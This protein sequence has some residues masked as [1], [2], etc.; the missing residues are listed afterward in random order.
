MAILFQLSFIA[1]VLSCIDGPRCAHHA[2]IVVTIVLENSSDVTLRSGNHWLHWK[3]TWEYWTHATHKLFNKI[4]TLLRLPDTL[5]TQKSCTYISHVHQQLHLQTWM[6]TEQCLDSPLF[7]KLFFLTTAPWFYQIAATSTAPP[8]F[9][10][11]TTSP[12]YIYIMSASSFLPYTVPEDGNCGENQNIGTT[13]VHVSAESQSYA[14][15]PSCKKKKKKKYQDQG[16]L[17]NL[18][19]GQSDVILES[20]SANYRWFMC[21]SWQKNATILKKEIGFAYFR[22]FEFSQTRIQDTVNVIFNSSCRQNVHPFNRTFLWYWYCD[23]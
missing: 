18:R 14:S 9:T 22:I 15:D 21:S 20:C 17:T 12:I 4:V 16:Y 6:W 1:I 2:L 7:P 19:I 10:T 11:T 23:W 3:D 13:S 8:I 5:L